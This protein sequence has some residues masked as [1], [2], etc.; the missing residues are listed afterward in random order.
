VV[1]KSQTLEIV[2]RIYGAYGRAEPK[3]HQ[4]ASWHEA[5]GDIEPEI[6]MAACLEVRRNEDEL[7][8]V[9]KFLEYV[10][11]VR[12]QGLPS[13][14]DA[15]IEVQ[16]AM[17]LQGRYR[18]PVFTHP[19]IEKAVNAIGWED[20]CNSLA[21]EWYWKFS[22]AYENAVRQWRSETRSQPALPATRALQLT[23]GLS[24]A[25]AIED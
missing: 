8:S 6:A 3:G 2:A 7:P 11:A 21:G 12:G 17:D 15:H 14:N 19:V 9:A 23:R 16:N 20:L 10:E 5:I 13:L 18:V 22:R 25:F 1:T 24:E 4:L